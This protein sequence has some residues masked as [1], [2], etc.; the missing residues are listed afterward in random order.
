MPNP[1]YLPRRVGKSSPHL[2]L[3]GYVAHDAGRVEPGGGGGVVAVEAATPS[4]DE[5][6]WR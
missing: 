1:R 3:L 4:S 6:S 5:L 2:A